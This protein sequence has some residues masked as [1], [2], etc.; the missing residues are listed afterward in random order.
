MVTH[1]PRAASYPPAPAEIAAR[2]Y[3]WSSCR[4]GSRTGRSDGVQVRP[5]RIRPDA[6]RLVVA[7]RCFRWAGYRN[8]FHVMK[9]IRWDSDMRASGCPEPASGGSVVV[10]PSHSVLCAHFTPPTELLR[11]CLKLKLGTGSPGAGLRDCSVPSR[12]KGCDP[13]RH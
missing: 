6:A 7:A 4:A 8:R 10:T 12:T 9:R 5:K 3:P 11:A 2:G 13:V 1:G